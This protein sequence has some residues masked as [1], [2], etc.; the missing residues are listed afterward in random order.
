PDPAPAAPVAPTVH[1]PAG[2]PGGS[3]RGRRAIE[4]QAPRPVDRSLD[5]S[6]RGCAG[7]RLGAPGLIAVEPAPIRE[8]GAPRAEAI[9]IRLGAIAIRLG[10]IPIRLGA[11][12]IRLG[13]IPIRLGAIPIRL[14]AG[15]PRPLPVRAVARR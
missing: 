12:P 11:I 10:A 4:I 3:G 14:G 1:P 8:G 9:A 6:L 15:L 5:R 13:A 2:C 7:I